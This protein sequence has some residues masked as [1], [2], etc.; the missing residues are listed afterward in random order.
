MKF[1]L[2]KEGGKVLVLSRKPGESL[3]INDN[4]SVTVLSVKGDR[5]RLGVVAD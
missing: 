3:V 5:V 1:Q 2:A 4:I